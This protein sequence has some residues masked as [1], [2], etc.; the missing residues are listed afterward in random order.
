MAAIT[1]SPAGLTSALQLR[2]MGA[3]PSELANVVAP[4]VELL[5]LFLIGRREVIQPSAVIAPVVGSNVFTGTGA[6]V[7]NGELW[8]LWDFMVI[9]DPG[10]GEAID[11]APAIVVPNSSLYPVGDYRA[12]TAAQAVRAFRANSHEVMY[13]EPGITLGFHVRSVTLAPQVNGYARITRL[14]I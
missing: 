12:A 3:L 5:P 13:L 6:Q 8:A 7:P 11:L 2:D 14:R 9:A 10:A 4:T 1:T